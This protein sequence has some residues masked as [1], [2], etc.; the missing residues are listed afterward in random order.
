M[1]AAGGSRRGRSHKLY[2]LYILN[3]HQQI[4]HHIIKKEEKKFKLILKM[5]SLPARYATVNTFKIEDIYLLYLVWWV[6]GISQL[7]T[8]DC[9]YCA[10]LTELKTNY[11]IIYNIQMK[12]TLV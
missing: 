4:L 11:L 2:K 12:R 1:Y 8:L 3:Q 9:R 7:D 5:F 10:F 6:A